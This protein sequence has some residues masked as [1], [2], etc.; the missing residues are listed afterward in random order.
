MPIFPQP[1]A[2]G[3]ADLAL[4]SPWDSCLALYPPSLQEP[5]RRI[6]HFLLDAT[7]PGCFPPSW[8][9]SPLRP[10]PVPS[11]VALWSKCHLG[12]SGVRHL[13]AGPRLQRPPSLTHVEENVSFPLKA[14]DSDATLL[15]PP[16]LELGVWESQLISSSPSPTGSTHRTGPTRP[17][18]PCQHLAAPATVTFSWLR[19]RRFFPPA[20]VLKSHSDRDTHSDCAGPC[21]SP[22]HASPLHAVLTVASETSCGLVPTY[23]ADPSLHGGTVAVLQ[24]FPQPLTLPESLL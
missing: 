6:Y 4:P 1:D 23:L 12:V 2:P 22:L 14:R 11:S 24:A 20:P 13:S 16:G 8:G 3:S 17:R 21:F 19:S 18:P 9:S 7:P 15:R 5:L 10:G